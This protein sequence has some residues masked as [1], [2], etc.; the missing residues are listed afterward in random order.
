MPP[1]AAPRTT[2]A[3]TQAAHPPG[4]VPQAGGHR[5]HRRASWLGFALAALLFTGCRAGS[6][7]GTAEPTAGP[8]T[9]Q[10]AFARWEQAVL[11]RDVAA[12]FEA[13]VPPHSTGF[14]V[15]I[16]HSWR[17]GEWR[18]DESRHAAL[19]AVLQK[20]S[21]D[22]LT[23]PLGFEER[24]RIDA[25]ESLPRVLAELFHAVDGVG[26][27]GIPLWNLLPQPVSLGEVGP[28]DTFNSAEAASR[29]LAFDTGTL[30]QQERSD[31]LRMFLGKDGRWRVSVPGF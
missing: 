20:H 5:L 14:L 17:D 12:Y 3:S 6:P 4:A 28:V 9:P 15:N 29:F 24:A 23:Q 8:D 21:L 10:A 16:V 2:P 27:R 22:T 26:P 25:L 11:Q 19:G 31:P 13:L 18:A 30:Q 1:I 7:T